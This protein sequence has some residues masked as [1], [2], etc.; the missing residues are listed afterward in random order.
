MDRHSVLDVLPKMRRNVPA[1]E[2]R[3][4]Q[5]Y[6]AFAE[7]RPSAEDCSIIMVDLVSFSGYLNTTP[8]DAP[9]AHLRQIEGRREVVGRIV[10]F[11][12]MPLTEV[13]QLARLAMEL[14]QVGDQF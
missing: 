9:D 6:K 1:A 13:N 7:C 4:Q 2:L 10:R 11:A 12:E 8:S 3:L 14:Q 5:A